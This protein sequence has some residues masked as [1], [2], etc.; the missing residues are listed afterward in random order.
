MFL[1]YGETL[2]KLRKQRGFKLTSFKHLGV[3]PS[4]L[5]KFERGISL[6]KFDKLILVLEELSVTLAEYEKC[7]N[8]FELDEHEILI[9]RIIIATIS[10]NIE[11][12]PN[13]RKEAI[14]IKESYLA[15][16]IKGLYSN[17]T[18]EEKELLIDYF[19]QVIFWRYTDLYTL[20]LSL[21]WL[22]LSQI[23]FLIEGFF[24]EN[25]EVFNS[26]EHRNRVSHIMCRTIMICISKKEEKKSSILLQYLSAKKYKHTMFTKNLVNFVKGYWESEFG[27]KNNGLTLMENSLSNFDSLS[28][29][30]MSNY[31]K[32]LYR[33]YTNKFFLK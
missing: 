2:K 24:N 22:E 21:D 8:N 13:F 29:P 7:L 17:L 16:A 9:Q 32:R 30:G 25:L 11:S 33:K 23:F 26:L 10:E 6:L 20:Y 19:E 31:Y 18:L 14:K 28:F 5:C 3:S 4:A 1:K 27:E 12:F 15:L